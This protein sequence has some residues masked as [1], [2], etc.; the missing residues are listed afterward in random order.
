MAVNLNL[1][2]FRECIQKIQEE[3]RIDQISAE[4]ILQDVANAAQTGEFGQGTEAWVRAAMA[5]ADQRIAKERGNK[6]NTIQN[7]LKRESI[8]K[9]AL[10]SGEDAGPEVANQIY[11]L[12]GRDQESAEGLYKAWEQSTLAEVQRQLREGKLDL[13]ARDGKN[14]PA[15]S[16]NLWR[17]S[18]ALPAE[19]TPAGRIAQIIYAATGVVIGRMNKAGAT[20]E[21]PIDYLFNADSSAPLMLRGGS[22]APRRGLG[23]SEAK[24]RWIAFTRPL[25]GDRTYAE[26]PRLVGE[27]ELDWKNRYLGEVFEGRTRGARNLLGVR[28]QAVSSDMAQRV[29]QGT[30]LQWKTGEAWAQYTAEYG[31]HTNAFSLTFDMIRKGSRFGALM[32]KLGSNPVDSLQRII[33]TVDKRLEGAAKDRFRKTIEGGRLEGVKFVPSI[34]EA[35]ADLDGTAFIP[36][37]YGP[38]FRIQRQINPYFTS[39]SLGSSAITNLFSGFMAYSGVRRT[40]LGEAGAGNAIKSIGSLVKN[41]LSGPISRQQRLAI[42]HELLAFNEGAARLAIDDFA[43]GEAV[44]GIMPWLARQTI[45]FAGVNYIVDRMR[46][47]QLYH[48]GAFFANQRHL[49]LEGLNIRFRRTL[50]QYGLAPH[51]DTIRSQ[52]P[53]KVGDV[54]YLT[55]GNVAPALGEDVATRMWNLFADIADDSSG[56]PGIRERS[57]LRAGARP[58]SLSSLLISSSTMFMSSPLAATYQTIGRNFYETQGLNPTT[59]LGLLITLGLTTGF[60]RLAIS[61]LLADKPIPEPESMKDVMFLIAQSIGMSGSLGIIGDMF[62]NTL[63]R[64]GA[65]EGGSIIGGP[66]IQLFDAGR[67][68]FNTWITSYSQDSTYNAWPEMARLLKS[69]VPFQNLLWTRSAFDYLFWYH[70]FEWL[71]PG[72]W[73]RSNSFMQ[74]TQGVTRFGYS[75]GAGVPNLPWGLGQ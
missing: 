69:H 55:P 49:P 70:A 62:Y 30:D 50:E 18:Q 9:K 40:Y 56:M 4:K 52:P 53:S 34:W 2:L 45:R 19:A 57:M 11:P 67:A 44:P 54:A 13:Q 42:A 5:L 47:G 75:P 14:Y 17:L 72:W 43:H 31:T 63:F 6:V 28:H 73:E 68:V 20:I 48:T 71:S 32:T 23:F 7:A 41:L 59:G 26:F 8:V 3:G 51:W 29:S 46:A 60:T 22:S 65:A 39:T 12:L 24:E 25:V 37:K 21:Q 27:S 38:L 35:V 58:G 36:V 64:P 74:R 10:A 66:P 61:N 16:V 1:T 15:I 33:T